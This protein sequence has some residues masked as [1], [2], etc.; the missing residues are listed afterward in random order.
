M[1][2]DLAPIKARADAATDGPWRIEANLQ[3]FDI[4]YDDPEFPDGPSGLACGDHRGAIAD[5]EDAEFI[6]RART[7]VPALV[8]EVEQLREQ[9]GRALD[10]I[11][12]A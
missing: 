8:A 5:L 6:A 9:L 1:S 11:G 4:V 10:W 2:L 12:G 3:W 7:D